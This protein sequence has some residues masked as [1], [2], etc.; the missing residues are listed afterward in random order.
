MR[1]FLMRFMYGRYGV[2]AYSNW[3]TKVA[4]ALS[5]SS[6]VLSIF[7]A[8]VIS[9]LLYWTSIAMFIFSMVRIFSRNIPKRA[10]QNQKFIYKMAA[11]KKR[12][13]TEKSVFSQRRFYHFYRCPSCNQRIRIPRGKGKIEISC[14]KCRTT[15]I[16]KS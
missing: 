7:D 9:S 12:F 8:N 11:F 1:N 16:K 5:I 3:L 6:L 2:D 15:F 13:A 4:L 14:P 10:A